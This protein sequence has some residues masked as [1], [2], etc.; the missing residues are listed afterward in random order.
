MELLPGEPGR[1]VPPLI[2]VRA[3]ASSRRQPRKASLQRHHRRANSTTSRAL[4]PILAVAAG[5]L[6]TSTATVSSRAGTA[7][8]KLAFAPA[9]APS[10]A[11]VA[12]VLD[13]IRRRVQ[14]LL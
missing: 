2:Y 13:T 4:S 3:R 8:I 1:V 12:H 7:R 6:P 11:E 9:V 10:D 5:S 14:R